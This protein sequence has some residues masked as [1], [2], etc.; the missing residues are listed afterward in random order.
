M[1][2][3]INWIRR[4]ATWILDC[5]T[6][7]MNKQERNTSQHWC[8]PG[9]P[10]LYLDYYSHWLLCTNCQNQNQKKLNIEFYFIKHLFYVCSQNT[11][12][13]FILKSI[14]KKNLRRETLCWYI[15][16]SKI[17]KWN[18]FQF[19]HRFSNVPSLHL[20]FIVNF[21]LLRSLHIN[22]TFWKNI[23]KNSSS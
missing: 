20:F 12:M 3:V 22:S 21:L 11:Y 8:A 14:Y 2:I 13:H 5:A 10:I 17:A 7:E 15:V 9:K 4:N 1:G 6:W 23:Y 16:C 18:E 19:I